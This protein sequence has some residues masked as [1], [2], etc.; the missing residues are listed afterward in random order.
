MSKAVETATE[1]K[2]VS[3]SFTQHKVEIIDS[4]SGKVIETSFHKRKQSETSALVAYIRRTKL[5]G[6]T[7]KTSTVTEVR[8][9]TLEFF[10]ENSE[11]VAS[12]TTEST[13][14]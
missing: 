3:K 2:M 9:M 6:A 1:V 12:P 8:E 4:V 10:I 11:V 13:G 5:G 14:V 7:A